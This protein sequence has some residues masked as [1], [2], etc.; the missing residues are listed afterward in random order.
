VL[1]Q[2]VYWGG[3]GVTAKSLRLI[4]SLTQS[5]LTLQVVTT[6]CTIWERRT[7]IHSYYINSTLQ[8]IGCKHV[9]V[10]IMV[11]TVYSLTILL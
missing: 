9:T 3:A 8:I 2:R 1:V 7:L 6:L 4:G 10:Q 11:D 5:V